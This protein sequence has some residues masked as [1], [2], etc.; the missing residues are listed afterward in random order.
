MEILGGGSYS[1]R[2]IDD[3]MPR[4]YGFASGRNNNYV[5]EERE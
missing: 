4:Y 2:K 3:L 5:A 1:A